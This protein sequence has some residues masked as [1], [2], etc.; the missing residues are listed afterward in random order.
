V[1]NMDNKKKEENE[2]PRVDVYNKNLMINEEMNSVINKL[3]DLLNDSLDE[4]LTESE[5]KEEE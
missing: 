2:V 4:I 3:D 5:D 1:E